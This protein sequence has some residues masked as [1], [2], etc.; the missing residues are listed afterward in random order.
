[1]LKK[2]VTYEDPFNPGA[3]VTEDLYFNFTKAELIE[4]EVE[5]GGLQDHLQK[6]AAAQNGQEIMDAMKGIILNSYGKRNGSAFIKNDKIREE[7]ESSEAYSE[8]FMEMVT[9]ADKAIEFVRGIL[10]KGLEEMGQEQLPVDRPNLT[11]VPK[12]SGEI[13][14]EGPRRITHAEA[15]AMNQ[16]ELRSGLAEGRY[17]LSE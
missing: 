10:P 12:P 7:F 17:I 15:V 2:T 9:D 5:V 4:W 3:T 13:T 14:G 6:I 11:E 16:E 8:L 1:M